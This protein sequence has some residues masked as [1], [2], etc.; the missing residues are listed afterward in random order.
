MSAQRTSEPRYFRSHPLPRA[1]IAE[2]F[3]R[4]AAACA[5]LA[6]PALSETLITWKK[7]VL[8][9]KFYAEGATFGDI[10]NDGRNDIVYGPFWFE[11]PDFTKRH[12]FY[13]PKEYSIV[14][15][16]DNF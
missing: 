9:T 1:M 3:V 11:G 16:S 10:N 15:Y 7:Q 2:R 12:T 8:E 14:G 13:E 4:C 5:F 6:A